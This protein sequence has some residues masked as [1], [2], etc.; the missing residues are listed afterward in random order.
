MINKHD[1]FSLE[2]LIETEVDL[3]IRQLIKFNNITYAHYNKDY[4]PVD[5][6]EKQILPFTINAKL[7]DCVVFKDKAY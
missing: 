2:T 5:L 4:G 3:E 7:C 6:I 1:I